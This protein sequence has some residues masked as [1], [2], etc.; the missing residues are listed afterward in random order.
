MK[1]NQKVKY[2]FELLRQE[3][4]LAEED[5]IKAFFTRKYGVY[6][7]HIQAKTQGWT[8]DKKAWKKVMVD[9]TLEQIQDK[10]ARENASAL[11][12]VLVG[13]KMKIQTTG[14]L[15]NLSVKDLQRIWEVFMT[16]NGRP[17]R[18]THNTNENNNFD[19]GKV[20]ESLLLKLKAKLPKI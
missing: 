14:D 12:N 7:R 2:D 17:T 19:A 9:K 5:E 20:R 16:M 11:V 1:K 4:F 13:L 3:F 10:E 15:K 8:N 6:N 18:I